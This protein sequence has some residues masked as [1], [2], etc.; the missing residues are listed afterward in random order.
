MDKVTTSITLS[1]REIPIERKMLTLNSLKFYTD[2]PRVYSLVHTDG[3]DEPDQERIQHALEKM[4]HV[5]QLIQAIRENGGL[6]DPLLVRGSDKAVLEGNSRLAA[7]NVLSRRDPIKWNSV[8]CDVVTEKLKNEDVTTLLSSYHI[9]GRKSWN[10]FEQAGMFWRWHKEGTPLDEILKRVEGMGISAKLIKK[11]IEVYSFMVEQHDTTPNRWS[12]YDE[13]LK[14]RDIKK[15]DTENTRFIKTV[16]KQIK[17]G[18][19]KRAVDVRTKVTKIA[20]ARGRALKNFVEEG[21][22][23]DKCYEVAVAG[24]ATHVLY[25]KIH[26]FR[27]VIG[28]PE[29]RTE[30]HD[31][32]SRIADK[33]RF[34]LEKIQC[35]ITRLLKQLK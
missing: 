1:G 35:Y 16:A 18:E 31:M 7:Y 21:K 34:D 12:H 3:D 32:P 8:K 28:A 23:L 19:I 14:N 6:T 5:K 22:S 4:D 10:P 25:N 13:L 20:K 24:G 2:N 29:T 11:W 30:V 9:I 33:C 26:K 27:E 15:V 17:T